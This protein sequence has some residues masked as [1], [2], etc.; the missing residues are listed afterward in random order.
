M[1]VDLYDLFYAN[2]AEA[3]DAAA[4]GAVGHILLGGG[5]HAGSNPAIRMLLMLDPLASLV[6]SPPVHTASLS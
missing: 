2:V 3:V 1:F 5:A 6:H 4:L